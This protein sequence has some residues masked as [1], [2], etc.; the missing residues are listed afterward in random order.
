MTLLQ[1]IREIFHITG[2]KQGCGNGECGAC[3]V[4]MNGEPVRS[5]LILAPEADG[6]EI[7]TLEGIGGENLSPLQKAFI[8]EGAI[9]CGFCTPGML[10]SARAL[11][12]SNPHPTTEEI[13][14]AISGNLCRCTG[15]VK[16]IQAIERV[17]QRG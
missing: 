17:A 2:T 8:E 14:L 4:I 12:D 9:Q 5:C 11:L 13:K 3:T 6:A 16:I 7:I 10:I 1:A 15:Y